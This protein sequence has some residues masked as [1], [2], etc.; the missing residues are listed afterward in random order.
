MSSTVDKRVVEMQFDNSQFENNVRTTMSTLDKLKRSLKLDGAAQGLESVNTAAKNCDM[1]GMS[2]GLETVKA[3]FSA[4]QVAGVTALANIT[5]SAVNAGKRLV[6]AF[7][8]DPIKD[9]FAEY[10][11][12]MNAVQ[13][14][15]A[16]TQKE[17]TNVKIVNDAL[18]ELN[19]YADKTIYNFTEMTRN[20]GTFTAAGVKLKPAVSA[21]KGIA[22]LGAVS[23]STSQQV[24]TAM[25]Q[26]SQALASGKVQLQDWNSVVN[27]GMG[28]EVFKDAL[29]RTS[30]HLK[31][32]AKNAIKAK[33][34]FRESLR[35]GWL[36]TE[37]LTQTLDQL[38]T[39]ADT[40]KEY[41]AAVKKFVKQGY[42]KEQAKD[43][44]DLAKTAGEA[45]TKVKTFT[46]LMGTLK[47]AAGSGWTTTW[48]LIIG[49][50]E[51]AKGLWT[52]VSNRLGDMINKSADARNKLVEGWSKGGGRDDLIDSITNS[53]EGLMSV[54]KPIK[55]AFR[56]IF[57]PV[58]VKQLLT[59]TERLKD[60]TSKFKLSA[61][62]ADRVKRIFKGL[63]SIVDLGVKAFAA[64]TKPLYDL[65]QSKGFGNFADSL[66]EVIAVIGD[67]F[68]TL[69]KGAN[70]K[71]FFST[72]SSMLSKIAD[73]ISKVFGGMPK[74]FDGATN[75]IKKFG[76]VFES[77]CSWIS[78]AAS[79][80]GEVIGNVF[81]WIKENVSFKDIL[82]GLV[83]GGIFTALKKFGNLLDKIKDVIGKIFGDKGNNE[84]GIGE[85][86]KNILDQVH[87]ALAS[88]TTGIKIASFVSIAIAI[89]ILSAA[90]SSIAKLKV[91]DVG[92]ALIAMALMFTMLNL[93][94][95]SISKTLNKFKPGEVVKAGVALIAMSVSIKIL[96]NAIAKL[97]GLDARDIFKGLIAIGVGLG[98]LVA[99]LK[100]VEKS[101]PSLE[102]AAI[103]LSLAISCKILASALSKFSGLSWDEI[104][105]GLVGMGGALAELTAS[106]VVLNKFGG[107]DSIA[108]AV[109][110]Y[111]LCKSLD[112][113]AESLKSIGALSWDEI[114]RGL[115]GMGGA[116]LE[117]T[118]SVV[119]L[120]K[121]G[122]TKSIAS[123]IAICLLTK[124]LDDIAESLKSIGSLSWDE[125]KKGLTGMGGA[126]AELALTAGLLGKFA[127]FSGIIGDAT[128][129]I[130]IKAL[131]PIYESLKKFGKMSWDEVGRGLAGMG[132]A[133]AELA[134]VAGLL[135]KVAGISGIVGAVSVLIIAQS[136][137]P[138][139]EALLSIGMLSWDE[140]SRGL[141]GMGGA[142]VELGVVAG[143][144]GTVAPLGAIAGAVSILI[145]AQS[146]KPISEALLSIG[147]LSWDEI[148]RGLVGMGGALVEL[149]LVAG[150]LGTVAPLGAIAG[151]VSILIMAQSLKPIA[152]ALC[153][154]GAL[155]WDEIARGLVGMG[156]ALTELAV[157]SGLLGKLG[158]LGAALGA[159]T[160][161]LAIQGLGDLADALKKFGEMSWDEIKRGLSAMGGALGEV[162][163]G[164][165]LN[166]LSGIGALS[167]SAIA[168]PLGALA[169]SVKKWEGVKVPE[170][171]S[172]Q[173]GQL[174]SGV[175]K[176][177]FGGLGANTITE[178][179]S[180]LGTLADSV[181]KWSGITIPDNLGEN[182]KQI[183][184]GV[185]A[186][187][188]DLAGGWSID[189][190]A[191]PLGTLADS[192]KKWSDVSVPDG[193]DEDLTSIANGVG[194]FASAFAGGW[195]IDTV[196]GPLGA[197]ADSVKK[198]S[199][200]SV[201]DGIDE[202]L[203]SIAKGVRSFSFA[204]AG[205]WS[206][207]AVTGPIGDLATAIAKWKNV[208][209]PEGIDEDLTAISNGVKSFVLSL[210]GSISISAVA[211]PIGTLAD[212][213]KKWKDV[214][215]PDGISKGLSSIASGIR[216][217]SF[218]LVSGL[219]MSSIVAPLGSLAGAVKR[220]KDVVVPP[221]ISKGLSSIASGIRSFSF[222]LTGGFNMGS[223]VAPLG[224]LAG[225]VKRWK[226]V[227]IPKSI[228]E[229]LKTLAQGIKSFTGAFVGGLSLRTIVGPLA[230]LG[231]A[232]KLFSS[233]NVGNILI[234]CSGIRSIG[235]AAKDIS[236]IDFKGIA[237]KLSTFSKSIGNIKISAKAFASL[238]T[239]LVNDFSRSISGAKGK[240]QSA[241]NSVIL[242]LQKAIAFKAASFTSYGTKCMN[243]FTKGLTSGKSKIS[244]AFTE[245]LNSALTNIRGRYSSFYNAGS[246][247]VSGFASGIS[248]NSYKAAAKAKAMASAAEQ[249]AR[250]QLDINSPSKVFRKIG[251]G[252]PE[253]F[254]QGIGK[255]GSEVKRSVVG[256]SDIALKSTSKAIARVADIVDADIDSQ[257]TI[258]P[259]LD[260]DDVR[261]GAST[262]NS[263]FGM[264]PSLGVLANVGSI[265]S[266]MNRHQNGTN[267]EV[268]SALKD[269]K[270]SI[271]STSGDTYYFDGITYDDGSN[272]SD[273]VQTLVRAARVERR[274]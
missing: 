34:T 274:R 177:T 136:L 204:F 35:E 267:D 219:N 155:S 240:V 206:M 113:I 106:V 272:I 126:L 11:T 248:S 70:T 44:A 43:M 188:L 61:E 78:K 114:G 130:L 4:L 94:F 95:K 159:G 33:G 253:G 6:S 82:A 232:V 46:Q 157:I 171:L 39:A 36:T 271:D 175:M 118:A 216:S 72:I 165:L 13:T 125:I 215:V 224:A 23:G 255:L 262:L 193:I 109:S 152:D 200:V 5:N 77:I 111:I 115:A 153:Q 26:L 189:T 243:Q 258:R 93:S 212:S 184:K 142:L 162:A 209:I 84:E 180:S 146:L 252:V 244:S 20:I 160:I 169:D 91:K 144:L 191:G 41:E 71:E 69:D 235:K 263:M 2:K 135:G 257:P 50:F 218:M 137:D 228:S 32:G 236:G 208:T 141:V 149:G 98:E 264:Q 56:E 223:I 186:F 270:N 246:Y 158:G 21:I 247:L 174:A 239:K 148:A 107:K 261:A 22:N 90:L 140:I 211:T 129:L 132:G 265:S 68:T 190:V 79:K 51:E 45:A 89:G 220:W 65:S 231:N 120:N 38:S 226:D 143:L 172:K 139:A 101:K 103:I 199:D 256:M 207:D 164:S 99:A 66:L 128:I 182:M 59:F 123:A 24:S 7:T 133:L 131:D 222:I 134:L 73:G 1:S 47:E 122:G 85:K 154:I 214:T 167:I 57:P 53:F 179:S 233:I 16:N 92:K 213:I 42:S 230:S 259:V 242:S 9:G 87:E 64:L 194:S 27:A 210:S 86:F 58:T 269:L 192:I 119:V 10:E 25:Y 116:L 19:T 147:M 225:A 80:I 105:R 203:S 198:W 249:A 234:A 150:L 40:E 37:V 170:D 145:I 18:D 104:S 187:T 268:V 12:Q 112:D 17:H 251:M 229:G 245:S 55:E 250:E 151:A 62:N 217:F 28:G 81:N 176:F 185:G 100:I 161:L 195:S 124:S 173:L 108:S 241:A 117:L 201:P 178:I 15:L 74:I 60:L 83:G 30:E 260:L 254:A 138:I 110:I 196:A 8:I 48:R 97:A 183:A 75:G 166:T 168:E 14:I 63:F 3:K 163:L 54:I 266:M 127:G 197:L 181:L 49:D 273:A 96:S 205:G 227:V 238:G 156:G 102:T 52:N 67:F 31:T 88:F 76:D 237:T 121:L 29:I 202:D 221:D